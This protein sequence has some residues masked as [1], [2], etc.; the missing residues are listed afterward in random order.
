MGLGWAPHARCC[1][2]FVPGPFEIWGTWLSF[3]CG[4]K[5]RRNPSGVT[6]VQE[7]RA[8]FHILI[9]QSCS[10]YE[11]A[12]DITK[13]MDVCW[14]LLLPTCLGGCLANPLS[15]LLMRNIKPSVLFG[16]M[17]CGCWELC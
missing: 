10:T 12:D 1:L 17:L 11:G 4:K 3:C 8:S 5:S 6:R 7:I 2:I 13:K 9:L 16:L 15:D 14:L